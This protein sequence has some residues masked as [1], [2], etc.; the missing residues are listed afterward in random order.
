MPDPV[1]RIRRLITA[2][3]ELVR[4]ELEALDDEGASFHPAPGEWCAKEVVGHL[5]EADRRGFSG[6]VRI[7]LAEDRPTLQ[8]WDQKAVATNRGDCAK[9]W[10]TIVAE[11]KKVRS[12]GLS[13]L[14]E[15]SA[16]DLDRLAMHP[17][18]G[19]LRLGDVLHEWPYHDRDHLK[20][21]LENTRQLLWPDMG[22]TQGFSEF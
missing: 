17:V 11:F 21:M 13:L 8:A 10:Q 16:G 7:M 9:P 5:I 18:V 12:S 2:T 19:E 3:T 20:Q 14:N 4:A 22:A 1:D 6:R 15:L